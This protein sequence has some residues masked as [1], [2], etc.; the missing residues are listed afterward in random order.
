MSSHQCAFTNE[1]TCLPWMKD[2]LT[3]IGE[4]LAGA[5]IFGLGKARPDILALSLFAR[6]ADTEIIDAHKALVRKEKTATGCLF[7]WL[8]NLRQRVIHSDLACC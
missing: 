6:D 4:I 7:Y 8:G 2:R 1:L 5:T 3:I